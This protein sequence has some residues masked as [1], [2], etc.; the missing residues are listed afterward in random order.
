MMTDLDKIRRAVEA[1]LE[2]KRKQFSRFYFLSTDELLDLLSEQDKIEV[3]T[4]GLKK[5][6]DNIQDLH[7]SENQNQGGDKFLGQIKGLISGENEILTLQKFVE[8]TATTQINQWL[9]EMQDGMIASL[10]TYM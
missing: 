7:K 2:E 8:M 5:F 10:K 9:N 4:D 6:F 3:V 1:Q